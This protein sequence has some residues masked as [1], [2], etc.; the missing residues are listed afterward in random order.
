MREVLGD[1]G[2]KN[3][4]TLEYILN[5]YKLDNADFIEIPGVGRD[6]LASL[7]NE[8]DFKSGVEIGVQR[9][10]YSWVL[11]DRNPQMKVYGVDS[12]AAYTTQDDVDTS[13]MSTQNHS[14]QEK[15]EEFYEETKKRLSP[16]PKYEIIRECSIDAMKHFEDESLDF[17]YIDANHEYS[18]VMDDIEGW[19]KKVRKGG[20]VSGHDYYEVR[21]IHSLMHVKR[22]V[23]DYV[24]NND[25]KPL[26]IWGLKHSPEGVFRDRRRSWSF[27]KQ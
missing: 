7:L 22:A 3:M 26:I 16:Y 13:K 20:I 5:K 19:S 12:W 4:N 18:Y 24:K 21:Y 6:N 11:C 8:L 27:I 10:K 23:D 14:S 25:I 9:G 2:N 17:V 15:L 1:N